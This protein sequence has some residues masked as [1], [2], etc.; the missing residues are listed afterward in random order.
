M[1]APLASP[2]KITDLRGLAMPIE[3]DTGA[4]T[5]QETVTVWPNITW[6][7]SM[8]TFGVLLTA[9]ASCA[10]AEEKPRLPSLP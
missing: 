3:R 7:T 10:A 9:S 2:S 4:A 5:S 8:V 6:P 1:P